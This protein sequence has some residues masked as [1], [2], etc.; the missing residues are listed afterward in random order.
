ME[1][2]AW[3]TVPGQRSP[4]YGSVLKGKKKLWGQHSTLTFNFY[5]LGHHEK[6]ETKW[7]SY[8]LLSPSFHKC[9]NIFSPQPLPKEHNSK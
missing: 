6:E 1:L 8:H 2:G 4:D 9:R 7:E 3:A 5:K